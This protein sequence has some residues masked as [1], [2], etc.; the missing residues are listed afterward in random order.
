[1]HGKDFALGLKLITEHHPA[2]DPVNVGHDR[3][4]TIKE[5]AEKIVNITGADCNFFF[6]TSKPEGA[7]RKSAE[8]SKLRKVTN[9]FVPKITLDQ[10]LEE[11]IEY[12]RVKFFPDTVV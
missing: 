7:A 2:A 4:T 11:M 1:M 10:G 5:L 12:F 8:V 9:G 6:D 3:E